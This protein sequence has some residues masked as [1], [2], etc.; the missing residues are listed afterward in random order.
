M[1]YS[2]CLVTIGAICVCVCVCFS[3]TRIVPD[4]FRTH[5]ITIGD[6]DVGLLGGIDAKKI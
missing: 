5:C 2:N 3:N 6:M 4:V 1:N